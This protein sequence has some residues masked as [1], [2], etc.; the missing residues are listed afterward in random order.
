VK[1]RLDII[2][3]L[4]LQTKKAAEVQSRSGHDL[5]ALGPGL[6][7][8]DLYFDYLADLNDVAADVA[9]KN[10]GWLNQNDYLI[11]GKWKLLPWWMPPFPM[12]VRTDLLEQIGE[13]NPDTWEDWLRVGKK[14]KA[15]GHPFGTALGHSADANVTLLSILWSYGGSYVAKDGKTITINSKETRQV[16][17]F[18]KRLYTGRRR[19]VTKNQ[20]LAKDFLRYHFQPDNLAKWVEA[21]RGFNMPFLTNQTKHP[22]YKSDKQY[23]FIPEV[24]KVSVPPSWPGP[25]TAASQQVLDLYIIP[26]MFAQHATGKMTADQAIAWAEKEMQEIYAGRKRR[27]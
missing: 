4:Q 1:V 5:T 3:H 16:M 26:D 21:G 13:K 24:A 22:V 10:G 18:V 15:I 9:P 25:T 27:P 14:G 8:A 19:P 11:R 12:A 7:D 20:D 6:G 2:A 17:D 23:R